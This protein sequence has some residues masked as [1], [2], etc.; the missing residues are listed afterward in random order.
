MAT[1][2][3]PQPEPRGPIDRIPTKLKKRIV[4]EVLY[5]GDTKGAD[6]SMACALSLVNHEFSALAAPFLF[7][8]SI[9]G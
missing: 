2:S 3:Q 6:R 8:V 5:G 1:D 7:K 9:K 4:E